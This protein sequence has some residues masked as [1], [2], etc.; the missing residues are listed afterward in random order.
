MNTLRPLL[1]YFLILV[2]VC[3]SIGMVLNPAF[4]LPFTPISLLFTSLVYLLYQPYTKR[5]FLLAFSGV[6]LLGFLSE[7]IGVR[8]GLIFGEYQYGGSLG[9]K[10]DGVPLL[11]SL[12]WALLVSAGLQ[13][14]SK[15]LTHPLY[16]PLMASFLITA[17]DLLME[18]SAT[19]LDYWSF[20]GEMAGPN[21]YLGWFLIS[22]LAAF[23]FHKP[24]LKGNP[25]IATYILLLQVLFFGTIFIFNRLPL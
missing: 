11:I 22:F 2:Y 14:A 15:V 19:R 21:N 7:W 8:T 1:F 17:L 4:F 5:H 18:Q 16:T 23:L 10:I 24:L 20:E 12:N 3:G 9:P 6:A 13:S 25:R